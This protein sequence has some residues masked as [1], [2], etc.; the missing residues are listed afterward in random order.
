MYI[1]ENEGPKS[2]VP[3]LNLMNNKSKHVIIFK[4]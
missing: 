2:L 4:Y 1:E 3:F